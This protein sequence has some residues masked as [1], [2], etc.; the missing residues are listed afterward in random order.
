MEGNKLDKKNIRP[1]SKKFFKHSSVNCCLRKKVTGMTDKEVI[2]VFRYRCEG[3]GL[4][5][6]YKK[7]EKFRRPCLDWHYGLLDAEILQIG[8]LQLTP[9]CKPKPPEYNYTKYKLS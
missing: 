8:G 5:H 4:A 7:F 1:H 3:N 9:D 6:E 2:S